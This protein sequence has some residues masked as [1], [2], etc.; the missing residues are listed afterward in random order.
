MSMPAILRALRVCS[1]ASI[2][3][4]SKRVFYLKYA[5]GST[6]KS[7]V[8][9]ASGK[10]LRRNVRAPGHPEAGNNNIEDGIGK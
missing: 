3:R 10:K 5:I 1:G 4:C 8:S 7:P 9:A 6:M 2:R